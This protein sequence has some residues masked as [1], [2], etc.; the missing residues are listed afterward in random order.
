MPK[1]STEPECG[2]TVT[3]LPTAVGGRFKAT[4]DA[5]LYSINVTPQRTK[6]VTLTLDVLR[7]K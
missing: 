3:E 1:S 7:E 6:K 4:F 5:T 2:L